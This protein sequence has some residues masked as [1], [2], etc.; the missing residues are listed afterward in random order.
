[1]DEFYS[2]RTIYWE[3]TSD[4]PDRNLPLERTDIDDTKTAVVELA[5]H[6][7]NELRDRITKNVLL[8]FYNFFLVPMQGE[9]WTEIQG[10]VGTL[11]DSALEQ[12]FEVSSTRE[13][14]NQQIRALEEDLKQAGEQDKLFM[15]YAGSFS[16]RVEDH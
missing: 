13:K 4:K 7:F 11:S 9:L 12:I 14:L 5:T 15:E 10:K 1:M 6:I 8:K 16:K 3:L 2:T